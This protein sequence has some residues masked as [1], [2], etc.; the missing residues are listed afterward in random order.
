M[1]LYKTTKILDGE[2]LRKH[3]FELLEKPE[4]MNSIEESKLINVS[5]LLKSN[6]NI[7]NKN[8]SVDEN[9]DGV[10]SLFQPESQEEILHCASSTYIK[11]DIEDSRSLI[12]LNSPKKNLHL[13][14][15]LKKNASY[16]LA[17]YFPYENNSLVVEAFLEENSF[18][19]ITCFSNK[20]K[21]L[22]RY[23]SKAEKNSRLE[24][25]NFSL[26]SFD[27]GSK[28]ILE[29][30]ASCL[31]VNSYL[32]NKQRSKVKDLVIHEGK[33]S[34]SLIN[35]KGYV[36]NGFSD[37]RGLIKI[38]PSAF[39]ARGF[40]ESLVLSEGKSIVIS[41]PD[42]EILNNEVKCSHGSVISRIKEEDLFYFE[43][44]GINKESARMMLIKGLM[45]SIMPDNKKIKEFSEFLLEG[46]VYS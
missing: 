28:I 41:V 20:G 24:V 18:A 16:D 22:T 34:S 27:S 7:L 9:L 36:I 13:I 35:A 8:V 32:N 2:S 12:F 25:V 21:I 40:Q 19:R 38:N 3:Y 17:I 11:L 6:L 45:L 4:L 5:N 26:S 42:L 14:L 46:G 30:E 15:N 10:L 23:F 44:R 39:E 31:V 43:S 29:E 37:F 33:N 1:N